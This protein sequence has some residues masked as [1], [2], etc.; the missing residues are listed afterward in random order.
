MSGRPMFWGV[1]ALLSLGACEPK[2]DDSDT[3]P[4]ECVPIAD[5]GPDQQ[6]T[7]GATVT[8]D[9]TGSE[10][11]PDDGQ[12]GFVYTWSFDAIPELSE[13]GDSDLS[14]NRT[15][16][17][18]TSSFVPDRPGTWVIA[19]ELEPGSAGVV[20]DLAV[21]EVEASGEPPVAD[22]GGSLEASVGELV[23]LD[24]SGSHDP[25]GDTISYAWTM[26]VPDGSGSAL[27]ASN[28]VQVSFVPDVPGTYDLLLVV[29]DGLQ[30]SGPSEC[31]VLASAENQPP[32]ADAGE[33]G[34]LPPCEDRSF[35][36]EGYGSYDPEGVPLSYAWS[37]LATPGG[38]AASDTSCDTGVPCYMAFD[39]TAIAA[40][41][42]TWDLEGEYSF[43]LTVSDGEQWSAP[44][45]V[46]YTVSDCP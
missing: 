1:I 29:S 13:L 15:A 4:V 38:S 20:Q 32:V 11:C 43:E 12:A 41:V 2:P 6:V 36:L 28:E 40:P 25:D 35:Q 27:H 37:L 34:A 45:V 39:D 18:S 17:A 24:G 7:L 21:I 42:F 26:G 10:P 9:G 30:E 22:C 46:T 19:L 3:E 23:T 16:E 33:G 31:L 8:L 5:A 44:D 14:V